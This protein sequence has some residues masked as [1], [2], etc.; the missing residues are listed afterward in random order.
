M[1]EFFILNLMLMV[2]VNLQT[3]EKSKRH[4]LSIIL[5]SLAFVVFCG[6]VFYHVWDHLL[7]SHSEKPIAKVKKIFKIPPPPSHSDDFDFPSARPG[8]PSV[9]SKP[10]TTSVLSMSTI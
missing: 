10:A 6:I 8:S 5:T 9:E 1:E 7:K 4:V 3:S 2:H